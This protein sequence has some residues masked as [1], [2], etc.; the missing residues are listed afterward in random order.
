MMF[1][2]GLPFTCN[3]AYRRVINPHK[4]NL[5]PRS[6]QAVVNRAALIQYG[7]LLSIQSTQFKK[8][9]QQ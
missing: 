7:L 6:C 5:N 1:F 3:N 4:K 2:L 8:S 9:K